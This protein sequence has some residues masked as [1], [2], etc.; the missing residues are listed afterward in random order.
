MLVYTA[1]KQEIK[2][3]KNNK[4]IILKIKKKVNLIVIH[5]SIFLDFLIAIF[6]FFYCFISKIFFSDKD[7]NFNIA[8]IIA[9]IIV[10]YKI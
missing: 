8:L 9:E 1:Q 3:Q 6:R 2:Y 5:L 4:R 7:N 10:E